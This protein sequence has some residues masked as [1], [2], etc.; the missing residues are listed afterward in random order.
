MGVMEGGAYADPDRDA[1]ANGTDSAG[2]V[3]Q[4]GDLE[5]AKPHEDE[6]REI[7][8][9]R[10]TW[11]SK[12]VDHLK[13]DVDSDKVGLFPRQTS[14]AIQLRWKLLW[15]AHINRSGQTRKNTKLM[16]TVR[17]MCCCSAPFNSHS[18]AS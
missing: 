1:H 2:S 13:R 9:P 14:H 5:A 17:I 18:S 12:T 11:R 8:S 10:N 15:V 3:T 16:L 4:N 6:A 7:Y